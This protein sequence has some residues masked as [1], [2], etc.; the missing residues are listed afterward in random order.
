MP[1][2]I[3]KNAQKYGKIQKNNQKSD[4]KNDCKNIFKK[5]MQK[6][7]LKKMQEEQENA[8]NVSKR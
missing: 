4:A 6:P 1:S 8:K 3:P 2:V 5:N 7:D